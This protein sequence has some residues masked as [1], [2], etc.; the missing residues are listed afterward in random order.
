MDLRSALALTPSLAAILIILAGTCFVLGGRKAGKRLLLLA[1]AVVALPPLLDGMG[2]STVD[3]R[4]WLPSYVDDR[5]V[6]VA[7]CVVGF[8]F[9]LN[10]LRHVLAVFVGYGSADSAVGGVLASAISS[11]FAIVRRPFRAMRRIARGSR[12]WADDS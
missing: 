3:W 11:V 2:L 5:G 7:L 10:L 8:L 9:A 12:P 6:I 4:K 1:F